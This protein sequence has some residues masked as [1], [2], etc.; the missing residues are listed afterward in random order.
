MSLVH[1]FVCV[2]PFQRKLFFLLYVTISRTQLGKFCLVWR[3]RVFIISRTEC[4]V[5]DVMP[6][7]DNNPP[8]S[9]R[10]A[11]EKLISALYCRRR[12]AAALFRTFGPT[13][14]LQV[15]LAAENV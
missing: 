14:S 7:A 11:R 8:V 12:L 5:V 15:Y 13:Y 3:I 4:S 10:A 2:C 9:E 6:R 1:Q